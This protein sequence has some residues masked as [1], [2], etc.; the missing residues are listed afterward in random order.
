MRD[1]SEG[2]ALLKYLSVRISVDEQHF[3]IEDNCGG[4]P[5]EVAEKCTFRFG[6]PQGMEDTPHS[7]GQFGVG[8]KRALFKLGN[9]FKIR[10]VTESDRFALDV[11]VSAWRNDPEWTFEF[12]EHGTND[13]STESG[14]S[15]EVTE[16]HEDTRTAFP[17]TSVHHTSHTNPWSTASR[18]AHQGT[19]SHRQRSSCWRADIAAA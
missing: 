1:G 18:I 12:A 7:I 15:I 17:A 4:I 16:L 19:G 14:T 3:R 6:R 2:W 13:D 11:N 9:R 5:L 8:M 10:S